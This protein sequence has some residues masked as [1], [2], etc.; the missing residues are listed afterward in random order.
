MLMPANFSCGNVARTTSAS[1]STINSD[2]RNIV[3]SSF[4]IATRKASGHLILLHDLTYA[5]QRSAQAR[6]WIT[7][8][9]A[10]VALI[11]TALASTFS[12]L[13]VRRWIQSMRRAGR[14]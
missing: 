8:A 5:E 9:L 3:V 12:L 13:I 11:G 6:T 2:G 4:P 10:G 1:F 7:I 14:H